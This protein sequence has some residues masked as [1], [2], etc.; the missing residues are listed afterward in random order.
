MA[1]ELKYRAFI[2]YSHDDK[3]WADWLHRA[4]ENYRVPKSLLDA[5]GSNGSIPRRLFPIYRDRAETPATADLQDYV[6]HA[7]EQSA[8]LIVI[9]SPSSRQSKW[10]NQEILNFKRLGRENR[11]LA[12]IVEGEPN[13]SEGTEGRS[14]RECFPDGL[15]FKIGSNGE[16]TSERIEPAAA[17]ARPHGDGKES[18]KLKLIAGLLGVNYGALKQ[19]ELEAAK[20]RSRN[21]Q[22]IAAVMF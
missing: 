11:V 18:A 19:R 5:S 14:A 4:L 3:K 10:V 8:Y 2:S 21:F 9:C 7:L 13:D 16:L 22:V 1:A 20:R 6:R 12:L 15:R 17:D